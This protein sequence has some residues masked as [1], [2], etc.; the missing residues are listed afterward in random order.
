[1]SRDRGDHAPFLGAWCLAFKADM[2][3]NVT[4]TKRSKR[5]GPLRPM[6]RR[7]RRGGLVRRTLETYQQGRER[8]SFASVVR[9]NTRVML[10]RP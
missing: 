2:A 7:V 4:H 8:I 5:L 3:A 9:R 1:M 10:L 6:H